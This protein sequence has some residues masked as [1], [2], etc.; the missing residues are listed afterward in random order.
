MRTT[1]VVRLTD[2]MLAHARADD[3]PEWRR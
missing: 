1:S 3:A 2:V